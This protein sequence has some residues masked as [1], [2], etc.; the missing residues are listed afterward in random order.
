MIRNQG[1]CFNHKRVRRIYCELK[2]NLK[3]KPRK[4][5]APR[6]KVTLEEPKQVNQCWSLDYMSDALMNGNKF[7][8]AN[9]IDDCN[10][11]ALGILASSSLPSA[12]ITRWLD[13]LAEKHGYPDR[14]RVDN[15]PENLSKHFQQWAKGRNIEIQYIQPGK[16]AQ[17]AYIERFNRTYREAVILP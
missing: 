16:P 8:T 4:R 6:T 14:I 12:R 9:V 3:I 15:G 2:L 11:G 1:Y 5:L 17:N 7:R 10:R 13:R